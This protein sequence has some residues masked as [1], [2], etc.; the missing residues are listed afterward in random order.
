MAKSQILVAE[1]E[2]GIRESLNLILSR[3]YAVTFAANGQ[4]ALD[5]LA[6]ARFDLIL[7]DIKMPKVDG[8]EIMRYLQ[9]Q[10]TAPA[11]LILTAYQ[12]VEMAKEAVKLGAVDYIS[13]PFDRAHVLD[14]VR[15]LLTRPS[16]AA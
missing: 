6:Q 12:S 16:P 3:D 1:D 8:L 10:P 7:L 15:D 5:H 14:T 4:E 11:V 13:K 2:E 9:R